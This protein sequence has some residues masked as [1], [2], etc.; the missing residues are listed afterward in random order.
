MDIY[1]FDREKYDNLKDLVAVKKSTCTPYPLWT[2]PEEDLARHPY[3]GKYGAHGIIVY[4]ENTP[5][6]SLSVRGIQKAG[7]GRPAR[8]RICRLCLFA[9]KH[10]VVVQ[11]R[12]VRIFSTSI[13]PV[14][15]AVY[16]FSKTTVSASSSG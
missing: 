15:S 16:T 7:P 8:K 6:D 12:P 5:R 10:A 9:Q 3:I 11:S 2:A 13:S 14:P 4:R 1:H